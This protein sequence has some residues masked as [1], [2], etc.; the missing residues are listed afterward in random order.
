MNNYVWTEAFNCGEILSPM[1][2]SYVAH[3]QT[4]IHVFGF[5]SDIKAINFNHELLIFHA[6]P[7]KKGITKFLTLGRRLNRA[8]KSGHKGTALFWAY[9]IRRNPSKVLIHLDS[10]QVFLGDCLNELFIAAKE[11][12]SAFG[13]RRPYKYRTYRLDGRD[14][15]KLSK[16]PD[17]LNTDCF[18]FFVN[19]IKNRFS[20]WLIRRLRGKRPLRYPVIDFF[21]PII[22]EMHYS[23]K[24]IKYIDSVQNGQH[25][26]QNLNHAF[27]VNRI[28]FAA[29]GSGLNFIK[30]SKARTS[31]SYK[32]FAIKS[33]NL[34][35]FHLLS[36]NHS[37][38]LLD[39]PQLISKLNAL[40]KNT[41]TLKGTNS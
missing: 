1:L 35:A 7:V 15:S 20:P 38:N 29:V 40:D 4:P 25:S 16:H 6:I 22:L 41:W 24:R 32:T 12:Y 8:Y 3:H 39:D 10:D 11:G 27:M 14:S 9:L 23:G 33:Y 28:S 37:E 5:S 2:K 30:N 17:T 31:E 13:S 36:L 34:F 26:V 19:D 21:D 18:G